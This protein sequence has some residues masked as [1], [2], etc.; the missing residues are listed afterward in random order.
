MVDTVL[1]I[2]A[3]VLGVAAILALGAVPLWGH[4]DREAEEAARSFYEQH[5]YWPD[6]APPS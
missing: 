4:R 6:E 2:V 1:S 5:G 3:V